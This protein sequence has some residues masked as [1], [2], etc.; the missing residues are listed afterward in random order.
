MIFHYIERYSDGAL[1]S[2][3]IEAD[4]AGTSF[5][6]HKNMAFSGLAYRAKAC[7]DLRTLIDALLAGGNKV[8][9]TDKLD[10]LLKHYEEQYESYQ[11]GTQE[12]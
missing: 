5:V 10:E 2:I 12:Q 11:A 1:N 8:E 6:T 7:R 3:G 4:M 9:G